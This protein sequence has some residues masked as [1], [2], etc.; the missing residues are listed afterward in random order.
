MVTFDVTI[1]FT[2]LVGTTLTSE[3]FVVRRKAS[4]YGQAISV[5]TAIFNSLSNYSY[6]QGAQYI[7]ITN[8]SAIPVAED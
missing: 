7:T 8:V 6:P 3:T 2:R 1:T 4:S 5:T